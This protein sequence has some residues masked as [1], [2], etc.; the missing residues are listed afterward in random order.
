M[1]L[2]RRNDDDYSTSVLGKTIED[3]PEIR[4]LT[5][6]STGD[7]IAPGQAERV[8]YDSYYSGDLTQMLMGLAEAQSLGFH[9]T[10]DASVEA[11]LGIWGRAVS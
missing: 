2:F 3:V 9:S 4:A 1:S 11:C 10:T 8:A 7:R 5:Y 6:T